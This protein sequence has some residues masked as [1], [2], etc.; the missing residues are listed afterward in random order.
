MTQ[1]TILTDDNVVK[2]SSALSFA[3]SIVPQMIHLKTQD[4]L[5]VSHVKHLYGDIFYIS[6]FK[7]AKVIS[8]YCYTVLKC[9]NYS[10]STLPL[11]QDAVDQ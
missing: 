5:R 11:Q 4:C 6:K 8:F 2:E 3:R 10:S 1:W 9:T 7:Q